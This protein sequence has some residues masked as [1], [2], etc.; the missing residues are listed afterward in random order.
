MS[1]SG[2][3]CDEED[4]EDDDDEEEEEEE[5]DGRPSG[6]QLTFDWDRHQAGNLVLWRTITQLRRT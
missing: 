2:K 4:D 6:D 1:S 3:I 5:E